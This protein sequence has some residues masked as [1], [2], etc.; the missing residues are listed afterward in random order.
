MKKL[1]LSFCGLL[2]SLTALAQNAQLKGKVSDAVTNQP[3]IGAVVLAN[4]KATTTDKEGVFAV[5]C[6]DSVLLEITHV[7]YEPYKQLVK[8]CSEMLSVKLKAG[9]Q[10]LDEV[11]ITAT[12]NSNKSILYQPTSI[13]KLNEVE[14]KRGTGLFLDDAINANVPGVFMERRTVSAGQQFNIRGYGNGARGTN[15]VNSNF[16]GQGSKVYLNGIP[17]TDAEGITLMD[18]IDFGSVGNVEVTKGPA[19]TLYGLAIAGVVNLKTVRAEKG[20]VVIGQDY[21]AGSYGLQRLTSHVQIGGERSSLLVNYGNQDFDGFMIHTASHKDF[22]NVV[23]EFQPNDKQSISTYFGY[24]NSYDQRNGELTIGQYDTLNYSGNPAYINNNAHS[25][26]ISFRGGFG[27]TYRFNKQIS[28]T[29]TVFGSGVNNNV[30][31]AGGWTDKFPVNYGL[32]STVDMKF[33]LSEKFRLSGITGTEMQRQDA[34]T[35]GY[36]M[37]KD[38][39]NLSGYNIIGSMKSNQATITKTASVFTEWTLTMPYDISFTAGVGM[40]N[41]YIELNDRFYVAA[42]NKPVTKIPTKYKTSYNNMMSPHFALNKVF[43][44]QLSAYASYSTGYKAPVSSYFFIPTTGALN[45]GLKAE[46]GTQIEIGTKG[47]LLKDKLQYQVA[48]FEAKFANK[49]TAIAVPLNPP[50]VGTAYTYV[51]N[52]GAQDNKGLEVLIKYTA[53]QSTTNFFKSIKPFANFCYSDFKYTDYRFQTLNATKT[54]IVEVDYSGKAVAGVAP[55]TA[56]GG[57]DVLT[58]IG[59]YLNASYNYRDA[60]PFTSDGVNKTKSYSL[61]NAK[62]GFRKVFAKHI[63]ADVFFGANNI[64]GSQYYYMVFLNQLPD[65]YMPAPY[66]INYFGGVNLKYIF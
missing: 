46:S 39:A 54:A 47:S 64:T 10:K 3:V 41:M 31:S 52:G 24:S 21:M 6:A 1:Y 33:E 37:V 45:T 48:V 19:G 40:S 7:T 57:I 62:I 66:E 60:M 22:V 14:L 4:G 26:I 65:A 18:D 23:G 59:L 13:V 2:I 44:K 27:H 49:M 56:N 42:N 58:K 29:T 5:D 34:S 51:A 38:S 20:K 11:E 25:N 30:S 63:D 32:R 8:N 55:I 53:Y 12:S 35:V 15:G 16:D 9:S 17:I 43:S 36:N 28:N 50:S 61:L